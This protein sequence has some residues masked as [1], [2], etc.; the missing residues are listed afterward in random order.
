MPALITIIFLSQTGYFEKHFMLCDDDPFTIIIFNVETVVCTHV[1]IQI[2]EEQHFLRLLFLTV[3][4]VSAVTTFFI[5]YRIKLFQSMVESRTGF[6]LAFPAPDAVAHKLPNDRL[7]C[8]CPRC[9][10][11]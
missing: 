5:Y 1:L 2:V 11:L 9:K 6:G 8:I 3:N 7:K 4:S 10:L